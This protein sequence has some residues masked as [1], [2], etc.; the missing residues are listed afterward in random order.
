MRFA[1]EGSPCC[2]ILQCFLVPLLRAETANSPKS[3]PEDVSET[4]SPGTL[5]KQRRRRF[6]SDSGTD[7]MRI[8]WVEGK[9]EKGIFYQYILSFGWRVGGFWILFS[10]CLFFLDFWIFLR[11]PHTFSGG[12]T[13]PSKPR[14]YDWIPRGWFRMSRSLGF[15]RGNLGGSQTIGRFSCRGPFRSGSDSKRSAETP[16]RR[17]SGVRLVVRVLG[18]R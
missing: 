3:E 5:R 13:G 9:P 11:D 17:R 8:S 16:R 2:S 7:L 10:G 4:L 15:S 14:G 12:T 18:L 1:L 6:G